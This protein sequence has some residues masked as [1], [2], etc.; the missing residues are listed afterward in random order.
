VRQKGLKVQ[1]E[2]CKGNVTLVIISL[3][4]CLSIESAAAAAAAAAPLH[5]NFVD[6]SKDTLTAPSSGM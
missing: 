6:S 2:T 1:L 3:L 5:V 4:L